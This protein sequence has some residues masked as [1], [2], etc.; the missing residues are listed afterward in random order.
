MNSVNER[1]N[2]LRDNHVHID[3]SADFIT[4]QKAININEI[5]NNI[6]KFN[7]E[8]EHQI[9]ISKDLD[10]DTQE[11]IDSANNFFNENKLTITNKLD[12][13][14]IVSENLQMIIKENKKNQKL[15]E[16]FDTLVST[17]EYKTMANE[18]K[19]LRD[20]TENLK[21]FLDKNGIQRMQ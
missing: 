21:V 5:Q 10:K 13:L 16:E 2:M 4:Q 15:D 11:K 14:K 18:M 6:D 1:L 20:I 12:E 3:T 17:Q 7:L 19:E 8:L 9:S